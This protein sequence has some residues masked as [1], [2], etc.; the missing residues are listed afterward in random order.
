MNKMNILVTGAA[1]FIGFHLCE[2]I[3]KNTNFKVY[4]VDNLNPYY[5]TVL[6]KKRIIELKKNK[7]FRFKKFDLKNNITYKFLG[8]KNFKFIFHLAAQP[9]VRFSVSDPK[10]YIDENI[11]AFTKVLEFARLQKCL[12][13]FFASSSS[14]YGDSKKFP[15]NE[16][17][18]LKPKNVYGLTKK[19]NEEL[20]YFYSKNFKMKLV[21]LRFFTVFGP[22]GRPDML[23]LKLLDKIKS[24]KTFHV[25]NFGNHSRDFT[26]IEDVINMV[27]NLFLKYRKIKIFDYFNLCS[28]NPINLM[29]I[30][31]HIVKRTGK[32]KLKRVEFQKADV[33]KTHGSNK[34]ILKLIKYKK[35]NNIFKSIDKTIDWHKKVNY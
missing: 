18:E 7:N 33:L 24:K 16:E 21:G 25:N 4:G 11:L 23:T 13:T 29:K 32:A 27:F 1:G 3:L 8:K 12:C 15:I 19:F 30:I 20:A 22:W 2:K 14:V 10:R 17:M 31:N 28:N 35:F 26:Y 34:K 6:K 5:S 9:G